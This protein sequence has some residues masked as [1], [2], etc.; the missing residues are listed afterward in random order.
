MSTT[1]RMLTVVTGADSKYARCLWQMLRSAERIGLEK[2]HRFV[3]FDLGIGASDLRRLGRRFPW[4]LLRAGGLD[5]LPAHASLES[6]TY[7]WKPLL[8][9]RVAGE[10]GGCLLWLD[11]ATLFQA[12]FDEVLGALSL[13]GTYTLAGQSPLQERCN[14]EV[15]SSM[16]APLEILD[17]PERVAGVVGIDYNHVGAR[18]VLDLWAQTALDPKHWRPLSRRH[19]PEQ[20]IL[21]I[22]LHTAVLKGGLSL[23]P[24]EVDIGSPTPVRFLSTRN[25]VPTWMP[26][27][28]DPLVRCYYA[29]YKAADQAM[30]RV[31]R[32]K[33]ERA[34]G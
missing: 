4:C 32:F 16:E 1:A 11:S 3:A 31:R 8:M 26:R 33:S 7:A 23:N 2:R 30:I 13:Y 28:L 29:A 34:G 14:P 10:F 9:H 22:L 24:G 5:R 20:A 17:Q 15:W 19:N 21:S 18:R 6:R 27:M 12:D 25:K